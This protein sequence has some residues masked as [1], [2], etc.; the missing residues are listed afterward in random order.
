MK[1]TLAT[2]HS[3]AEQ[4]LRAAGVDANV[5]ADLVS[6]L[7]ALSRAHD[8]L[9]N[10]NWAGADLGQIVA[11]AMAPYEAGT[12]RIDID[13]PV[14]RLHPS[15]AVTLALVL[16]ELAT[17]AA[18]YGALSLPSSGR[19]RISWNGSLDA[20]GRRHLSLLWKETGGPEV[21]TPART[22]FGS[23]LIRQ[24]AGGGGGSVD[25]RFPPEGLTCVLSLALIDDGAH[26][27][28]GPD[29]GREAEAV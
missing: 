10:N 27:L 20:A 13:G 16:H 3:V 26:L 28:L 29:G 11:D 7:H 2:V 17:N 5:R 15:Q 9:V 4:T 12:P 22:G 14:V 19:V 6:R 25:L 23:K 24:A 21:K 8:V 1:N 18:K